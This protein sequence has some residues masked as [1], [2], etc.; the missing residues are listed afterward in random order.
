MSISIR[1]KI[2]YIVKLFSI[3]NDTKYLFKNKKDI[4][5]LVL[6]VDFTIFIE[7]CKYYMLFDHF[8]M[9]MEFSTSIIYSI[10]LSLALLIN[11]TPSNIGVR[12]FLGGCFYICG[13]LEFK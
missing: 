2:K 13:G 7:G 1:F 10:F 3:L 4:V 11:I 12:E 5:I 9:N 6:A 8:S